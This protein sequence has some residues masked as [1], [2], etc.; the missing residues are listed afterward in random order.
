MREFLRSLTAVLCFAGLSA[1][2]LSAES[3]P[4][5]TQLPRG[6]GP[7][8]YGIKLEPNAAALSFHGNIAIGIEVLA[9]V[10]S[11]TLNAIDMLFGK[12]RLTDSKGNAFAA[13]PKIATDEAEQTATFAF[14]R[15]IP[16]GQY[17]LAID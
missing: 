13:D 8:S 5:P 3:T 4:T 10:E 7:T 15:S 9:P 14:G 6:V 11:I 2:A 1:A 17:S 12:V 16:A